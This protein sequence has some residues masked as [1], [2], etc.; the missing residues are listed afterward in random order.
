MNHR[1]FPGITVGDCGEKIGI[2][3]VDN[4]WL[5]FDQYRVPKDSLLDK[6]SQVEDDGT[7]ITKFESE[8]KRFAMSIASLSGGRVMIGRFAAENC[9]NGLTIAIRHGLMR[10]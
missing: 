5:R 4:G 3:G 8:G 6:I 2:N 10:R 1:P 9:W 7:Y